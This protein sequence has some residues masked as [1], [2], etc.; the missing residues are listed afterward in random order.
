MQQLKP[1]ILPDRHVIRIA[2]N[3][4]ADLLQGVITQD[5]ALISSE[6][7]ILSALLTPQGKILFDFLM[8][9]DD[10][11][12]LLDCH[13]DHSSSLIKKLKMYKLRAQATIDFLDDWKIT[14]GEDGLID[15][16]SEGLPKR[17]FSRGTDDTNLPQDRN[18]YD[19]VR[20]A[21][22]IAEFGTDYA[23]EEMFPMDVNYDAINGVSYQ[24]GCFVGQ[25]VVSRMKRKT[26][27]RRRT[28]II[29]SEGAAPGKGDI[30]TAGEST[31]GNFLHCQDNMGLAVLRI[32]RLQKA[33]AENL[34]P[35]CNDATLQVTV[36]DYL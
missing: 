6:S 18:A 28:Y 20:I 13:A 5:I 19:R 23:G 29:K 7:A 24:K 26:D 9:R 17:S 15:K 2:G 21:H 8:T 34:A 22:G 1:S 11:G 31:L 35:V 16:R 14:V 12:F 25:E 33:Q 3:D 32:D 30:I 10:E 4:A 27:P 36:P